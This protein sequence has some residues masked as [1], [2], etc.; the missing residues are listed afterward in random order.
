MIT[1]IEITKLY[2]EVQQRPRDKLE[3]KNQFAITRLERAAQ[4][5]SFTLTFR[6]TSTYNESDALLEVEGRAFMIVPSDRAD[7]VWKEWEE[8]NILPEEEMVSDGNVILHK[9]QLLA[10]LL[11]HEL[12]LQSPLRLPHIDVKKNA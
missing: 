3:V 12:G 2:G 1:R 11:A 5:A 10:I 6:F 8:K 4:P 7:T 9:A